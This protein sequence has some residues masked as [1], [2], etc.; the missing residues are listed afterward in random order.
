MENNLITDK[1]YT[2]KAKVER[3]ID[4]DTAV[5]VIDLGFTVQ[6]KSS[7]RLYGINTYELRSK[8]AAEK[9][10]AKEAKKVTENYLQPGS[11]VIVVSRELDKYGR[12]LV[13]IYCTENFSLHLNDWLLKQGL[14]KPLKY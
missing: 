7:C 6:W 2:Y 4:G 10:K 13:D 5:L 3:V 12:P 9:E 1:L 11:E 14:A 8:D